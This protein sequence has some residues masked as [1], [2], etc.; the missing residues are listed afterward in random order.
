MLNT[1]KIIKIWKELAI[2]LVEFYSKPVYDDSDKYTKAKINPY[3]DNVNTN[4]Q[5]KNVP[6]EN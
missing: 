2:W 5:C 1:L 3:G 6:K 4:F